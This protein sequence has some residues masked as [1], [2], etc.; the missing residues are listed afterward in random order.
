VIILAISAKL[1]NDKSIVKV[2]NSCTGTFLLLNKEEALKL[3]TDL[4][5]IIKTMD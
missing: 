5:Y 1:N 2:E 3:R 4:N